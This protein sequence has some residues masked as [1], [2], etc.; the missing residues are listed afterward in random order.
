M[1]TRREILTEHIF[2]LGF[3]DIRVGVALRRLGGSPVSVG[4]ELAWK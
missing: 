3:Q 1:T 4:R 2:N